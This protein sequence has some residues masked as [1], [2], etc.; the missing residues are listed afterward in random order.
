MI[1]KF[2][3]IYENHRQ[4]ILFLSII[5]IFRLIYIYL[6][7]ILPQE[8][9]YWYYA[10]RPDFSYY[11][12]PPMAA[13]SI[14]FGTRLFG[15]TVFG[16]KFMAV[17]W[18]AMTNIVLYLT[19]HLIFEEMELSRRRNWSFIVVVFY[20][21]MLFAHIYAVVIVPDTPLLFFWM[22][23]IF[24]VFK[25]QR[26]DRTEY[27]YLAA[28]A[29]GF[30]MLS[31]YTAVAILPAVFL[32]LISDPRSRRL[33]LRPHPYLA[34][35]ITIL[36][37]MPVIIWNIE[38]KWASFGFQFS[39][40]AG[41]LKTFQTKYILQL[42]A[43][44]FFILTPMPVILFFRSTGN[45]L[46]NWQTRIEARN[47]LLTGVFI[48]GGFILVS[49]RSLVKM[50][51]LMPGYLGLT[52]AAVLVLKDNI[53]LKSIWVKMGAYLSVVLIIMAHMI[54]LIRNIPLGEGNTWSGWQDA[55]QKIATIQA[56]MG[57]SSSVF[58]FTNSYKA[59]S[60]IKFYLNDKQDVYA[61]NIYGQ[62]ALQ[63]DIWGIPDTLDGKDALY[64]F[65][66]RYEY[67]SDLHLVNEYFDS[68]IPLD[69]FRYAFGP[70]KTTRIISCYYAR[71]YKQKS[72]GVNDQ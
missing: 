58:I 7:P 25:Y 20:N 8:A 34:V 1:E 47:L 48:I 51:W 41:A 15:D 42:I 31:K 72:S 43:S 69:E 62:P 64:V 3:H 9:Y 66:D 53:S 38:N 16:V 18:A 21:L 63:F 35:L 2:R 6:I 71:D 37:F 60:L 11:D 70:D 36:I 28:M 23:I 54:F 29:L 52:L 61:Q 44:Q 50:N 59:S 26:T 13:Y 10:L 56:E 22:S 46:K 24:F 33:F 12:H 40:R 67:K 30:G 17:I 19:A 45:I 55:T 5:T 49:L 14:W 27:V 32:I 4:I 65:S 39:E 57:G 68:V